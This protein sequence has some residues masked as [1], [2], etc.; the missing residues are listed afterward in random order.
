MKFLEQANFDWME[1][2]NFY[3]RPFRAKF[4]PA[5][6]WKDL[7]KYRND[8]KGLSNY[9]KKW[10]TRVEFRPEPSKSKCYQTYVAM[11]GEYDPT[12]RQCALHVYTNY[13]DKFPF[14]DDSWNKFKYRLI[15]ITMH[16]LIHF[17]Q[18]DRR[19]DEWSGYVVPYKKVKHAKKCAERKYLSEFDEIQ[20]YA[21][22]VL[23]DFKMKRPNVDISTLL[24]RCKKKR[25]SKTLHYFLK[26]FDYDFHNNEATAKIIQQIGKWERKYERTFRASRRPK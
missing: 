17:M 7:D 9:F 5:K 4:I 16:E 8:S 19:A 11:G 13:Y 25:D 18:F 2:L 22:D 24:A 26:T 20:A 1:M 15:Q 12:T 21:H 23:I 10:R 3:E 14:T 6:A